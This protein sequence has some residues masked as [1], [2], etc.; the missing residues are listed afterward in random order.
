MHLNS[1]LL[2]PMSPDLRS[3]REIGKVVGLVMAFR[4]IN[5]ADTFAAL[6]HASEDLNRKISVIT[7]ENAQPSSQPATS[8]AEVLSTAPIGRALL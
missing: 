3:N 8:L 7:F 2:Q 1:D 6:W 4:K 5:A